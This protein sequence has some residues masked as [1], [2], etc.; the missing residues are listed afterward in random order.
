MYFKALKG[1]IDRTFINPKGNS[2]KCK[3]F[4]LEGVGPTTFQGLQ[5]FMGVKCKHCWIWHRV[6]W[7]YNTD[8]LRQMLQENKLNLIWIFSYFVIP[9]IT[10]VWQA[11]QWFFKLET[12]ISGS[13]FFLSK[14]TFLQISGYIIRKCITEIT[15]DLVSISVKNVTFSS[16]MLTQNETFCYCV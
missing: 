11:D 13:G 2:G 12:V 10:L 6:S 9:V 1:E 3:H 4:A 8:W 7:V 16:L 5:H 14:I 15:W